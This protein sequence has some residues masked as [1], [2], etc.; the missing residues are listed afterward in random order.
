MYLSLKDKHYALTNR[1]ES[2]QK[3]VREV[4][5]HNETPLE[6]KTFVQSHITWQKGSIFG[7]RG[8]PLESERDGCDF[9]PILVV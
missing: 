9:E 6:I 2:G 8:I 7:R 3:A 4:I 1:I 5:N